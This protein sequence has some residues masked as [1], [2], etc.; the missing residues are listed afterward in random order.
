MPAITLDSQGNPTYETKKPDDEPSKTDS[1]TTSSSSSSE[2]CSSV[3]VTNVSELVSL[4]TKDGGDVE[5]TTVSVTDVGATAG[6]SVTATT[7]QSTQTGEAPPPPELEDID[8]DSMLDA[9]SPGADDAHKGMADM[10]SQL[11]SL[12]ANSGMSTVVSS[13]SSAASSSNQPLS[14][15]DT[16]ANSTISSNQPLSTSETPP[17]STTSSNPPSSTSETP[18]TTTPP[19]DPP[20]TTTQPPPETTTDKAACDTCSSNLGASDCKADDVQCLIDQCNKD[21]DCKKCGTPCDQY[22]GGVL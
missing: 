3:T 6:C 17:E 14:T 4:I 7:A 20:S 13:T 12:E 1:Q 21:N 15:T 10:Y 18:T 9:T 16:P 2:E 19:P 8:G 5:T 22:G 11:S